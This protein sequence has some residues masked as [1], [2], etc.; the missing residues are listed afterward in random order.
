MNLEAVYAESK[1]LDETV[2]QFLNGSISNDILEIRWPL[3]V[4][5]QSL[6]DTRHDLLVWSL[7]NETHQIMAS[8]E[9]NVVE[10]SKIDQEDIRV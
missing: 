1:K 10:L 4:P 7:L 2:H 5:A 8:S 9:E 6:P 3:G